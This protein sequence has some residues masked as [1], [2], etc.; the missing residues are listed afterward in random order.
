M[1]IYAYIYI[2]IYA[3]TMTLERWKCGMEEDWRGREEH[4]T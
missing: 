2:Y 1:Y 3:Y 4:E